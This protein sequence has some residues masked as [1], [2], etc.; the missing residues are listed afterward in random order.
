M[1]VTISQ[2]NTYPYLTP[3]RVVATSNQSGTYYN[4]PINNGVKATLTYATGALTIDSV[5]IVAG[6]RVLLASQTSGLQNGIYICTQT[7]ATGVAAILQRSDDYQCIEQMRL[8]HYVS[9]AAGTVNHGSIYTMVE[10]KPGAVGVDNI[11]IVSTPLNG[12]AGPLSIAQGGTGAITA[13]LALTALGAKRAVTATY[14]GGGTSN[15]FVATGLLSTD[16]VVATIKASTN[17]VSITKAV[18]TTD[19]LTITFSADPGAS[20]TVQWHALPA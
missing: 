8:G 14:A 13:P 2:Y 18:P 1:T 19:T 4:G 12:S 7:G 6:D 9:I 10:P 3:C 15:A 5:A 17:S 11:V 20:T 16:I